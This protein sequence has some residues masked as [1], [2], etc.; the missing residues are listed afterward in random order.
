MYTGHLI[1]ELMTTVER[2]ELRAE[3]SLD[4]ERIAEELHAIF[5]MQ[6][7]ATPDGQVFMGAA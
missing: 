6:I 2:A 1:S 4:E 3:K 7:P 5:T